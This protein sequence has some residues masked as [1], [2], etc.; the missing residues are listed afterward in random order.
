MA[1]NDCQ[2]PKE[3]DLILQNLKQLEERAERRA[4]MA[5]AFASIGQ[6]GKAKLWSLKATQTWNEWIAVK[7]KSQ[8]Q[9]QVAKAA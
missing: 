2:F 9:Q 4:I 5:E 8:C 7:E 3:N 1:S 6:Y